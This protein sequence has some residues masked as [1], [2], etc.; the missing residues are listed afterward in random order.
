[1]LIP[2]IILGEGGGLGM[3]RTTSISAFARITSCFA[4]STLM[5]F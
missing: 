4:F 2:K 3:Q 5:H 1:M